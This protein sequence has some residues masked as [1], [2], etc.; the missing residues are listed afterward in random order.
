MDVVM[1]MM[2]MID[3]IVGMPV[4]RGTGQKNCIQSGNLLQIIWDQNELKMLGES[5]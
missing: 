5:V 3:N 4:W 2:L 1:K